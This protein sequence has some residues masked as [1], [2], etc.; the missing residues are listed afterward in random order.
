MY[1]SSALC[2]YITRIA[3][4]LDSIRFQ[5][6]SHGIRAYLFH[7]YVILLLKLYHG[8]LPCCARSHHYEKL[9]RDNFF[10]V[11]GSSPPTR[12][13]CWSHGLPRWNHGR[14]ARCFDLGDGSYR[15][16]EGALFCSE[17]CPCPLVHTGPAGLTFLLASLSREVL[18]QVH[19]IVSSTGVWTA[20]LQMFAS[21]SRARHIQLRGQLNNT[22]KGGSSAAIYFSKMKGFSDELAAAGK[23]VDDDDLVSYILQGL[24]SD[25][26][27]YV[28]A[29]STRTGTDQQ[30]GLTELYSLL[31]TA[32][33]RLDAQNGGNSSSY[34]INLASKGGPRNNSGRPTGGS[35]GG[36]GTS[37]N[38]SD[39]GVVQSSGGGGTEK[40]QICKREGHA[41]WRCYK[42]FDKTFNPPPKR[43]GGGGKKSANAAAAS[44]GVDTNWYLDTGATD[45]VTGE[46]EKLAVRDRYT[47]PEQIHT[48]SGQGNGG[49]N[50]SRSE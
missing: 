19:S 49:H 4:L 29:L 17:P 25:Y 46:L 5:P 30:I 45:H 33:A 41:A 10:G 21:Q 22:K 44:Y 27:P 8:F 9:A 36:G 7:I 6:I 15:R 37:S 38:F 13:R 23:P 2:A 11:E 20:I 14:A 39:N 40:C 26:N 43:Q 1:I 28:A 32:E 48:A 18:L 42:R 31:I 35:Y 3:S 50:S 34:S 24:D 12:A 47:G 16:E